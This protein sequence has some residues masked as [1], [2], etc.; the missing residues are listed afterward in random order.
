MTHGGRYGQ[1]ASQRGDVATF[2]LSS[3]AV[4]R[5]VRPS[6]IATP[7]SARTVLAKFSQ[8]RLLRQLLAECT[9][10]NADERSTCCADLRCSKVTCQQARGADMACFQGLLMPS[11]KKVLTFCCCCELVCC[12]TLRSC[13]GLLAKAPRPHF[14]CTFA[15]GYLSSYTVP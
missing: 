14:R 12:K 3:E 10:G 11:F 5:S 13:C 6:H 7:E 4:R 2:Q 1:R 9:R 15:S 8:G